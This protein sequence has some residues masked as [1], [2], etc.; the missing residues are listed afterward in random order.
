MAQQTNADD[1]AQLVQEQDIL[2]TQ[3]FEGVLYTA[4]TETPVNVLSG[5]TPSHSQATIEEAKAFAERTT[6]DGR[7][8]RVAKATSVER[9]VE[10][11]SKP[12]VSSA[13][14]HYEMTGSLDTHKAYHAAWRSDE[15]GVEHDADY[16][17]GDLTITVTRAE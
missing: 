10:T 15:F 13:F 9:Q 2:G 1:A 17:T 7:A 16:E 12:Y 4:D 5:E 14:F 8:P 3:T 6:D 11:Q